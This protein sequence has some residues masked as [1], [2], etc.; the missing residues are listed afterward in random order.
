MNGKHLQNFHII[1]CDVKTSQCLL[2]FGIN[3]EIDALVELKI[4]SKLFNSVIYVDR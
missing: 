4:S 3:F 2:V 1:S